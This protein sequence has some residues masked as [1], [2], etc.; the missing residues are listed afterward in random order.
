MEQTAG[1]QYVLSCLCPLS[2]GALISLAN[3][4]LSIHVERAIKISPKG[5]SPGEDGITT[6]MVKTL[7]EFG[8]NALTELYNDMYETGYIP[9]DLLKSVYITLPKKAKATEC[10]DH[11][12]ISLMPHITKNISQQPIFNSC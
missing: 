3:F 5:K 8:I 2:T 4:E 1:L 12:T 11:R 10:S 6:E 9:Q 7:E